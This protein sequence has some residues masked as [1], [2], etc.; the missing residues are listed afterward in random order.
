MSFNAELIHTF[1]QS[2]NLQLSRQD[3][4]TTGCL[5][6][7]QISSINLHKWDFGLINDNKEYFKFKIL[8]NSNACLFTNKTMKACTCMCVN[9]NQCQLWIRSNG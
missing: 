7:N 8:S 1:N 6:H 2:D 4:D 5:L 3:A 9:I